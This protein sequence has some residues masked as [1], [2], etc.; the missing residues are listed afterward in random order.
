MPSAPLLWGKIQSE[1]KLNEIPDLVT[2]KIPNDIS[3]HIRQRL[4]KQ[5]DV[6][7]KKF[8]RY[9]IRSLD[10][11]S[12]SLI[13]KDLGSF[14]GRQSA[15]ICELFRN[16]HFVSNSGSLDVTR[17]QCYL[18]NALSDGRKEKLTFELGWGQ[19][20]RDAGKLRTLGASADFAELIAIAR[21]IAVVKSIELLINSQI[22]FR[23]ITGGQRFRMAL[24][25]RPDIDNLYNS[26]RKKFAFWLSPGTDISFE[27]IQIYLSDHEI[28]EKLN[29]DRQHTITSNLT[30][31]NF[32]FALFAIDWY[33]VLERGIEHN[34]PLSSSILEKFRSLS[35]HAKSHFLR[36]T[37]SLI[38]NE[39]IY[40]PPTV[41]RLPHHLIYE[42]SKWLCEIT[43]ISAD[44]YLRLGRITNRAS[45]NNNHGGHP[46]LL[47]VVLK[48]SRPDIP[49]VQLL[50]RKYGK[51]LPQHLTA[52][53]LPKGEMTFDSFYLIENPKAMIII[54]ELAET[55]L[56]V[57]ALNEQETITSINL[58]HL[59]DD[60]EIS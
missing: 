47:T 10:A 42:T 33:N 15:L 54:P 12:S 6:A 43:K 57:T 21:I 17:L 24:F 37:L 52:C 13:Y 41:H 31:E 58:I 14:F 26:Q 55:P 49:C 34:I 46:I 20:K 25:T 50:G 3:Q 27:N 18:I 53:L 28:R 35:P 45:I 51:T 7:A 38:V 19:A 9:A 16:A 59:F 32:R 23:V 44:L 60:R 30:E 36:A 1:I 22:K 2:Y 39:N 29:L 5:I 40:I 56:G 48:A 8:T 4:E 11:L